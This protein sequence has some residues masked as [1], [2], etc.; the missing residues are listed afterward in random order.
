MSFLPIHPRPNENINNEINRQIQ[1]INHLYVMVDRTM[2]V[3]LGSSC[4]YTL[5][6]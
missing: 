3:L 2:E 6:P 1:K 4:L 5:A